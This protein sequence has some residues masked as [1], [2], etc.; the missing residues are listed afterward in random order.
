MQAPVM[1][2]MQQMQQFSDRHSPQGGATALQNP[3]NIRIMYNAELM[4]APCCRHFYY[5][6]TCRCYDESRSYL[7]LRENSIESNENAQN[8]CLLYC[9]PIVETVRDALACVLQTACCPLA[10]V[11]CGCVN[12]NCTAVLKYLCPVCD[13]KSDN[14]TVMYFDRDDLRASK[15]GCFCPQQN[16]PKLEVHDK[17]YSCCAIRCPPMINIFCPCYASPD[18]EVVIMPYESTKCCFCCDSSN[19]IGCCANCA[20][21]CGPISG[22]PI[23]YSAF[24]PQPKNIEAFVAV[25]QS[26]VLLRQRGQPP[27]Q[28]AHMLVSPQFVM[29]APAMISMPAPVQQQPIIVSV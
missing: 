16:V 15:D 2:Q 10:C 22:S 26:A 1:Q 4:P 14:I 21:M 8:C 29:Q 27:P 12:V 20:G 11:L 6:M 24:Y 5:G 7:Y 17:A 9:G 3:S 19:R 23:V 28:A 25:A 18:K 13:P